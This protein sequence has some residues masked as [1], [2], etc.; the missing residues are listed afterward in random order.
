VPWNADP[1]HE[2]CKEQETS[3]MVEP[4]DILQ[5]VSCDHNRKSQVHYIYASQAISHT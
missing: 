5:D 3:K 4:A 1:D 2:G